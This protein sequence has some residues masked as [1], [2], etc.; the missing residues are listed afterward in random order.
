MTTKTPSI[1]GTITDSSQT[2][3]GW[4]AGAGIEWEAWVD[5]WG[6]L[7]VKVEYLHAD[8]G[9]QRYFN[10]PTAIAGVTIVS[11]DVKVTDDMARVGVNWKFNPIP[12]R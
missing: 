9:S 4:T 11:R 7:T 1:G 2:R 10:P 6:A 5:A 3:I 12:G 8:F